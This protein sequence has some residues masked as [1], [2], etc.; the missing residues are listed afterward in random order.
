[1]EKR[2]ND[3]ADVMALPDGTEEN[4]TMVPEAQGTA[5]EGG[6]AQLSISLCTWESGFIMISPAERYPPSTG[7]LDTIAGEN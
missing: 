3:K 6:N 7:E 1:M 2:K 4:A 5:L